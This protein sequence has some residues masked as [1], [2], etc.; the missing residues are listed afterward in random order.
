MMRTNIVHAGADELTYEIREVLAVGREIEKAGIPVVWENI[1]DPIAKGYSV[2]DWIRDIIVAAVRD[3]NTSF[4]Y[5]PTKGVE[6][7][8]AFLAER[9]RKENGTST[10]ADDI[11]FFNGIGDAISKVYTY[12]H[13]NARVIGPNPAYPTHSSAEGA[14]AGSRHLTYNLNPRRNWLPDIED[15]RNKVT[16]NSSI[17]GILIINPDNPTG[18]VYP[19]KVLR[20]I[21]AIARE[22]DLFVISDEIYANIVY[23][24]EPMVP[25][26]KMLGDVPG[27]VMRGLSKEIPWPGARCGWVE[28]YNRERDPAFSRYV[29][30]LHDAKAL[31]V[32]STTLPQEVIPDIFGDPRYAEHLKRQADT[33]RDHASIAHEILGSIPGIMVSKPGGAFYLTVTFDDAV[34][35][36]DQTLVVENERARR[37]IEEKLPGIPPDRRFTYYLLAGK[38]ICVVPLS[39]FNSDLPGFRVT[40]LERD[41][42]KLRA[43]FKTIA[44]AIIEYLN[45]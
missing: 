27:I 33:I 18:L 25:L 13:K 12:L 35:R 19:E 17:A 1:G 36:G 20:E 30:T 21:V 10:T 16:Y 42:E 44:G 11:L 26:G 38:G 45:S 14:H 15:L 39:G 5:S 2:P 37:L 22:H 31:E 6:R 32:C 28:V 7:T 24:P 9:C 29:K 41:T 8:R 43:H 3:K 23:G 4:G 40:L 34:L